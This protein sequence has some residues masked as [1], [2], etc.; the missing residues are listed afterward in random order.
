MSGNKTS[1]CKTRQ[2]KKEVKKR[3][4]H[5]TCE[6]CQQ[7]YNEAVSLLQKNKL[8]GLQLYIK[9]FNIDHSNE[10]HSRLVQGALKD[11]VECI[12]EL[13][14]TGIFITFSMNV[15]DICRFFL[16]Y[17]TYILFT[18]VFEKPV[19]HPVCNTSLMF[20]WRHSHAPF[21]NE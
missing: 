16:A 8:D 19:L 21:I 4:I 7:I 12:D 10:Q 3:K 1:T 15:N 5:S 6:E 13:N 9:L 17:Q 11:F 20:K 18:P 2:K 14:E